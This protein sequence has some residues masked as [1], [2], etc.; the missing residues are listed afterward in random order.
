MFKPV[1]LKHFRQFHFICLKT[2]G[3]LFQGFEIREKVT[4]AKKVS[5][6]DEQEDV[7]KICIEV[8]KTFDNAGGK[9]TRGFSLQHRTFS[10]LKYAQLRLWNHSKGFAK[11]LRV[12]SGLHSRKVEL[13][14]VKCFHDF[15][16]TFNYVSTIGAN[17]D[18]IHQL[19]SRNIHG[20]VCYLRLYFG[21]DNISRR[22]LQWISRIKN[23]LKLRPTTRYRTYSNPKSTRLIPI[24]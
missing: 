19:N 22:L 13:S 11:E 21:I 18:W 16:S 20:P 6:R 10:A 7:D 3:Y 23:G 4:S 2:L 1:F 15:V 9:P 14:R 5:L 12:R 8:Q 17:S 24:R